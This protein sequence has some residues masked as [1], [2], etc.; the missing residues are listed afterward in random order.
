MNSEAYDF[1]AN[2]A[3]DAFFRNPE[4]GGLPDTCP[5]CGT[6]LCGDGSRP[7]VSLAE[8]V[9]Y[10]GV[11]VGSG[12]AGGDTVTGFREIGAAFHRK[13]LRAARCMACGAHL[14]SL[15]EPFI[16]PLAK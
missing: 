3:T 10:C 16:F 5:D 4:T 2:M 7:T 11:M 6:D 15:S 9:A 13:T 14:G 1:R 12:E 8:S